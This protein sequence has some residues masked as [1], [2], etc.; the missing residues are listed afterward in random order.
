MR[1]LGYGSDYRYA[2]TDYAAME[3]AAD[4]PPAERLQAYLPENLRGRSYYQP[5]DQGA[6]ARIAVWIRKRRSGQ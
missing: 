5:G 4:L 6:E 1:E 3:H 2:H